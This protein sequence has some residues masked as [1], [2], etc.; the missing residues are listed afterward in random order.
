MGNVSSI[1]RSCSCCSGNAQDIEEQ[2]T[3]KNSINELS[4]RQEIH[5]ESLHDIVDD[6]LNNANGTNTYRLRS[7]RLLLKT[8]TKDTLIEQFVIPKI[9]DEL[10]DNVISKATYTYNADWELIDASKSLL[11]I[12]NKSKKDF[13][14]INQYQWANTLHKDDYEKSVTAWIYAKKTQTAYI[15]KHRFCGNDNISYCVTWAIP[16]KSELT[17]ALEYIEGTLYEI[18]REAYDRL[19][20]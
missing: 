18:N 5:R 20:I 2:P 13:N 14:D 1:I 8:L 11:P 16:K 10:G 19:N 12:I 9:I 7:V 6:V 15:Q 4:P 17:G 3:R